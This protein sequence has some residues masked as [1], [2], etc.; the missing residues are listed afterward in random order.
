[1]SSFSRFPLIALFA[2]LCLAACG[3]QPGPA[4]AQDMGLQFLKSA[5]EVRR[6]LPLRASRS[7][8]IA[9]PAR[10]LVIGDSLAQGFGIFLDR[11]I[12]AQDMA[13][14][15]TNK[16]RTSTGL[17]RRDFYD[18]P[19]EFRAQV[20]EVRPDVI[21]AHF[22]ANDRQAVV[23]DEGTKRMSSPEWDVAYR[24]EVR[25]ILDI[26]ADARAMVYWV[27]P[28]PNRSSDL[29]AHMNRIRP[30]MAEETR[31][32]RARFIDVT[33]FVGGAEGEWVKTAFLNGKSITIRSGDGSHYTGAGYT[34]V[35]D[36]LLADM[37]PRMPGMFAPTDLEL[38]G[39]LQ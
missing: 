21:I 31:A 32:V 4:R 37:E 1:M 6:P 12:V 7:F 2:T 17:A 15:V 26:A 18:W 3:S 30:I 39:I 33:S 11:R 35:A 5:P 10:I 9:D 25:R 38:A 27:G 36:R 23:T 28:A 19:A 34:M 29:D 16:G 22:G 20:A 13:A 8:S 14:V 24:A